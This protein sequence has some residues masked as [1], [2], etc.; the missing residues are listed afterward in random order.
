MVSV[1]RQRLHGYLLRIDLGP[2][3]L[4]EPLQLAARPMPEALGQ[5]GGQRG[6]RHQ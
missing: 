2:Q 4:L 1:T 3:L 5:T 6:S